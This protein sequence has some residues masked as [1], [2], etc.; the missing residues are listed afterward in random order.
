M[1][2]RIDHIFSFAQQ[3]DLAELALELHIQI[4]EQKVEDLLGDGEPHP[5]LCRPEEHMVLAAIGDPTVES[6]Q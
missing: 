2:R 1:C 6:S 4:D 5:I 3:R